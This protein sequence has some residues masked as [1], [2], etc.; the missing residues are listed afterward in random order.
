MYDFLRR[1]LPRRPAIVVL[2]LWYTL[3]ILLVYALS[4]G[5]EGEFNYIKL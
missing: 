4:V 3:L 2:A 1:F 5:A